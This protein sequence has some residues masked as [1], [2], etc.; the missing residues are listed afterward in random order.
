MPIAPPRRSRAPLWAAVAALLAAVSVGAVVLRR[1]GGPKTETKPDKNVPSVQAAS[2]VLVPL[3]STPEGAAVR[4]E[5]GLILGRTP[6][7]V[8]VRPNHS[9]KVEV[10]APGYETRVVEISAADAARRIELKRRA[11]VDAAPPKRRPRKAGPDPKK[12]EA[13]PSW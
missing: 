2:Q 10:A 8:P 5:V 12:D 4:D 11:P 1:G 3:S 9:R 13:F 7:E 6:L